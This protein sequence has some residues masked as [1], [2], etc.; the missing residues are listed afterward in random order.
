YTYMLPMIN[1]YET[2]KRDEREEKEIEFGVSFA[3][4]LDILPFPS[5][6]QRD[7]TKAQFPGLTRSQW[8]HCVF[9]G[10]AV[11]YAARRLHRNR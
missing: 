3:S 8:Q 2:I 6:P 11:G 5:S 4:M 9:V 10:S 1:R 7:R